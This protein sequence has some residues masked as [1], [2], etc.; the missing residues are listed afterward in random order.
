MNKEQPWLNEPN[1]AKWIDQATGLQCVIKRTEYGNLCGYV[2]L[3]HGNLEDRIAATMR[4]RNGKSYLSGKVW[5]RAGYD[6]STLRHAEVHGGLTYCGKLHRPTGGAYRG[7]WVGF[8]CAHAWDII[9]KLQF[10]GDDAVYRDFAYVRGECAGLAK[11]L[12]AKA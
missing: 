3:P 8:D 2:R 9:P 1:E 5:R 11:R 7:L 12:K 10:N 6:H 4:R